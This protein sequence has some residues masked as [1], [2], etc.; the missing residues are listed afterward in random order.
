MN[1]QLSQNK[2]I[3]FTIEEADAVLNGD[4]SLKKINKKNESAPSKINT[5]PKWKYHVIIAAAALPLV[6][7]VLYIIMRTSKFKIN[8]TS[9]NKPLKSIKSIIY[10]SW[11]KFK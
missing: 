11:S 1:H 2:N 7:I 10:D 9:G 3:E 5:I 6:L 4:F 8:T